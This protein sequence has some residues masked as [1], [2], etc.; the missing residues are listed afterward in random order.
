MSARPRS[1]FGTYR[2]WLT[3]ERHREDLHG[4]ILWMNI[5]RVLEVQGLYGAQVDRLANQAALEEVKDT[6]QGLNAEAKFI[7][8]TRC[9][10]E[11]GIILDRNEFDPERTGTEMEKAARR[12]QYLPESRQAMLSLSGKPVKAKSMKSAPSKHRHDTNIRTVRLELPGFLDL[13][14]C[15][16]AKSSAA[17]LSLPASLMMRFRYSAT[18]H[19][20]L[21]DI[22][23]LYCLIYQA[24]SLVCN[25][26]MLVASHTRAAEGGTDIW[27][28]KQ[29]IDKD[30]DST[31]RLCRLQSWLDAILW[32]EDAKTGSILRLKGLV[33]VAQGRCQKVVQAVREVYDM[34]DVSRRFEGDHPLNEIVLIGRHLAEEQLLS[35]L[36][37]CLAQLA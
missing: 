19:P 34:Q 32:E 30:K 2:T 36:G 3:D 20:V 37:K 21:E 1:P 28:A 35:S 10:I 33:H 31:H 12:D 27:L 23:L 7:E 24:C 16:S 15:L 17:F 8:T 5:M 4:V 11:L 6:I 25:P 29:N 13:D 26:N 14:R 22:C 18:A 9:Q